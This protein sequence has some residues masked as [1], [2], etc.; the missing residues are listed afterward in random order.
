MPYP[1]DMHMI[2]PFVGL[3]LNLAG[4]ILACAIVLMAVATITCW[5]AR[6][7][8]AVVGICAIAILS[9]AV[10]AGVIIPSGPY[11]G[12]GGE[13]DETLIVIFLVTLIASLVT[14]SLISGV[15]FSLGG[16]PDMG[17]GW[18]RP[19]DDD[20]S[21][22]RGPS[23]RG[24]GTDWSAFDRARAEWSRPRDGALRS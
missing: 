15:L 1:A 8:L 18:G 5:C 21:N 20:P 3:H 17:G 7:N 16:G 14:T 12:F 10:T 13:A 6:G 9:S 22:D 24:T 11:K 23:P 19:G 2:V 4:L